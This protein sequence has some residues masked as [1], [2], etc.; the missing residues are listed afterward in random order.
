MKPFEIID[1]RVPYQVDPM[2][3]E[4]IDNHADAKRIWATIAEC[5]KLCNKQIDLEA[6]RVYQQVSYVFDMGRS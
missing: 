2:T 3:T 1:Q 6:E 4:E 5:K